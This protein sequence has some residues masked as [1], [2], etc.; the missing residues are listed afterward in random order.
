MK[1]IQMNDMQTIASA[2]LGTAPT[3]CGQWYSWKKSADYN[4]RDKKRA[5]IASINRIAKL[6]DIDLTQEEALRVDAVCTLRGWTESLVLY[7]SML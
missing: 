6:N 5:R 2:I 3:T 7:S 1:L 4:P